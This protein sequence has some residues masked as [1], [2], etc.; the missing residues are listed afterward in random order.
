M[1]ERFASSGF[2]GFHD[3]EVLEFILFYIFPQV[4]TKPRAKALIKRFGG[5]AD[6]LDAD[7]ADIAAVE[8]MGR[9][10]AL[11]LKAFR[12]ALAY[13]HEES[14][15]GKSMPIDSHSELVKL[16]K[17]QIGGRPE[18]IF[19]VI[20]FNTKN[21]I[22]DSEIIS[23]GTVT[24]T[25]VYPRK[26]AERA[27]R[28]HATSI[29]IAHN[30]PGGSAEPTEEDLDLTEELRKSL[31]LMDIQLAEHLIIAEDDSYSFYKKGLL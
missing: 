23:E 20:Y 18:E 11:A 7:P 10:S 2:A 30:H 5:F 15:R 22:L 4:D 1:R 26:V 12:S 14:A 29:V 17:S 31:E 19:F 16:V 28:C 25:A 9:E 24:E 13:Y 27:L 3:Y 21:E 6:V 8:G